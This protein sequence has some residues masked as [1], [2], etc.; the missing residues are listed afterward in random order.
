MGAASRD[1]IMAA[2]GVIFAVSTDTGDD[3]FR[4]RLCENA[5]KFRFFKKRPLKT[6]ATPFSLIW[7]W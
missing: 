7:E 6:R 5:E 3:F 1:G 4:T 2:I